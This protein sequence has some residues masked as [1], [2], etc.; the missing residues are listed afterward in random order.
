VELPGSDGFWGAR[1]S[2]NGRYIVARVLGP[3]LVLFD[4]TTQTW[5]Q[6]VKG[7]AGFLNWSKDGQYVYYMLRGSEAA[8]WRV[9]VSDHGVEQVA[10]LKDVRQ[11][12][13]RP[14]VW[15][16]LAPDDSPL[17]LRDIGTQEIYALDWHAP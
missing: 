3:G 5:V 16:G 10:S 8:I 14:G 17:V 4:F 6:L 11:T 7:A 12:G 2:P 1:L 13:W 15:T 9:R